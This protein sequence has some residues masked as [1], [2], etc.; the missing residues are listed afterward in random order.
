ML[1]QFQIYVYI[2]LVTRPLLYDFALDSH[3]V[4]VTHVQ[5]YVSTARM[6]KEN[7]CGWPLTWGIHSVKERERER[8]HYVSTKFEVSMTLWVS[9]LE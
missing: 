1:T 3:S 2:Y 4:S 6:E 9:D 7:P 5:H 8:E